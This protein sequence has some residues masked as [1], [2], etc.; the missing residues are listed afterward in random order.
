MEI[1][2]ITLFILVLILG[3]SCSEK[4]DTIKIG[5]LDG[6]S[7]VSFIAMI[8]NPPVID[9]KKVE[10]IIHAEPLHIQALMMQGKLDFAVL[11]T[12]M[13]ANLYNKGIDYKLL[14]IPV[15]G[16][17]Y[18]MTNTR[19]IQNL[20]QL[21]HEKVYLF[22]RGSTADILTRD[23][24]IKEALNHIQPDYSYSSNAELAQAFLQ[25]KIN[26]AVISEPM[27]SI[28][29]AKDSN[30]RIIHKIEPEDTIKKLSKQTFAQTSFLVKSNLTKHYSALI[31]AISKQYKESCDFTYQQPEKTA[32]LLVKHGFYPD[33]AVALQSIP[34]CNIRFSYASDVKETVMEYLRIFYTFEPQS[35]GG[36]M[37]ADDFI[38]RLPSK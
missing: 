3:F 35:T 19:D 25:Q 26:F 36:K 12:V 30:I 14:A 4:K 18:L 6:P 16:T 2:A 31:Q 11:P 1:K 17:L 20:N 10:F 23:Y 32:T 29:I 28:L 13:A 9:N 8:D 27:V 37:P 24:L 15:W 33:T 38:Y 22:G 34:R 21:Q 7:A 5:L